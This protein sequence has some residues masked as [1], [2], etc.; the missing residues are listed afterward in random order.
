MKRL[1]HVALMTRNRPALRDFYVNFLAMR[2]IYDNAHSTMVR[3]TDSEYD[4]GLVFIDATED[5]PGPLSQYNHLGFNVA[6]R[7]EMAE[8]VTRAAALGV[9]CEGP[10]DDP[11]I[12][13]YAFFRDPDGNGVELSTP[14]GVN[15]F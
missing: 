15:R 2:V 8:F 11:Y 3:L 14:E 5:R 6:D 13:Y 4:C 12:G 7:A 9:P 1:G 10:F